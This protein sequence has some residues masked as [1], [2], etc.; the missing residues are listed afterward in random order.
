[1]TTPLLKLVRPHYRALQGYVSAGMEMEKSDDLIFLNANENPYELPGLE[2]F[3]CYPKPQPP[4]LARG[5]GE[6]YGTAPENI[7][8]T[9]GADE[10]IV[11]LTKILCEP[12]QD[13]IIINPPTFGMYKVDAHAMP[14][15]V[16]E[17]PLIKADTTFFLNVDKIIRTASTHDLN[18]KM[19]FLCSPNN[20]TGTAFDPED[21]ARI[22]VALEGKCAVILDETYADF[23]SK[24]SMVNKLSDHPNLIILRTLSK[25]YSMAGMRMGSMLCA[26][27]EF[28]NLI[29]TKG[30]DAYP[31]PVAS[32][33]AAIH[34]MK[35]EIQDLA[36]DHIQKLLDERQRV[37]FELREI[38]LVRKIYESEA[39]FLLVV[40][41]KA[42][43]FVAFAKENKVILRDF[44]NK[45]LTED[46][47]RLSIG[48]PDQNDIVLG[49]FREF[50]LK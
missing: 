46:C 30:L 12:E 4:E 41:N 14:A 2:G 8:M 1:M 38:P 23:S 5:Y 33:N 25:S 35:Q 34:V 20:P 13:Q 11:T 18:I 31:L 40:M 17:I 16:V 49:L 50:S 22:C 32:I 26:D 7:I 47:I 9:R 37:E 45:P 6:L 39:N 27:N 28:T 24:P 36:R 3:N 43:E 48:T 15:G 21:I 44:S 42:A 19:V 10:A 29:R